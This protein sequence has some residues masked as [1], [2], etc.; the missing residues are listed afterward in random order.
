M[1]FEYLAVYLRVGNIQSEANL[2]DKELVPGLDAVVLEGER[3]PMAGLLHHPALEL[4][5]KLSQRLLCLLLKQQPQLCDGVALHVYNN[6]NMH[7]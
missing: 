2:Q 5:L 3:P 6:N 1:E 7:G 4:E